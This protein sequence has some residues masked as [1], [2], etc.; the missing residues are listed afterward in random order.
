M[1]KPPKS[2]KKG[3]DD[4]G[5]YGVIIVKDLGTLWIDTGSCMD[6]CSMEGSGTR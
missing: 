1:V 6:S 4:K 2:G 3:N 5:A